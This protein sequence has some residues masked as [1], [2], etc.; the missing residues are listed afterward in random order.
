MTKNNPALLISSRP[1]SVADDFFEFQRS[2]GIVMWWSRSRIARSFEMPV[3]GYIYQEGR[4]RY[5]VKIEEILN[6]VPEW[7]KSAV[8]KEYIARFRSELK[9]SRSFLKIIGFDRLEHTLSL[10]DFVTVSGNQL[11]AAPRRII[12]VLRKT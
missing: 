1:A 4:I 5:R 12:Y 9:E 10:N 6:D 8:P 3:L 7:A 2:H 11:R